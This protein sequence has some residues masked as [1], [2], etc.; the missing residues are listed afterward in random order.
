MTDQTTPPYYT[1]QEF[2]VELHNKLG[3]SV[4]AQTVRNWCRH[5]AFGIR[6]GG[7]L[8]SGNPID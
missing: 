3:R 2:S 7:R 4:T 6:I 8:N 5:R 1:P